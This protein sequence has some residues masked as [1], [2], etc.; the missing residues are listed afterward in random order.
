MTH[1]ACSFFALMHAV[2][3]TGELTHMSEL[4]KEEV[5][6]VLRETGS[7]RKA[8]KKL[9]V[10]HSTLNYWLARYGYR[11][12]KQSVIVKLDRGDETEES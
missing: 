1:T 2:L 12:E 6:R 4:T 9:N 7:L 11:V 8:A 10:S 3:I 5:L